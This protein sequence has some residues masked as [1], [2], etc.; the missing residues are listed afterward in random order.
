MS[1]ASR[2]AR[3]LDLE[4]TDPANVYGQGAFQRQV[5]S[6]G[7]LVWFVM[8][9]Q[10]LLISLLTPDI[11]Y[12]C[13]PPYGYGNLSAEEWQ[14]VSLP[15][16]D[17]GH[18]SRCS[19][20]DPPLTDPTESRTIV[21]C[22]DWS[23][24]T[25][26]TTL[27]TDKYLVC[28]RAWLVSLLTT[29]YMSGAVISVPF[30]GHFS[31]RIGRRP[32]ISAAVLVLILA[33]YAAYT[34]QTL[35]FFAIFRFFVAASVSVAH[36]TVLILIFEIQ[37]P[38]YRSYHCV[39]FQ[40]GLVASYAFVDGVG[41]FQLDYKTV[42][43]CSLVPTS[44]LICVFIMVDE[45]P[46]WLLATS[47]FQAAEQVVMRAIRLNGVDLRGAKVM[48]T[49]TVTE[50][51]KDD[52][53]S[54]VLM[55]DLSFLHL[56]FS[57]YLRKRSLILFWY[58]YTVA[59]SYY[60]VF[61]NV[62]VVHSDSWKFLDIG[63][64][65]PVYALFYYGMERYGRRYLQSA[66]T[67]TF[68][69]LCCA[70]GLVVNKGYTL[71]EDSLLT[72]MK[73]SLF[74][75][76][77]VLYVYN[78]ELYPTVMRSVGVTSGYFFGRLGS[79]CAALMKELVRTSGPILPLAILGGLSLSSGVLVLF[80]PETLQTRLPETLQ[81]LQPVLMQIPRLKKRRKHKSKKGKH[82]KSGEASAQ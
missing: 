71:L 7:Q 59:I 44:M 13:K 15:K 19:M 81:D 25:N 10:H 43:L 60:A 30:A 56:L 72:L 18:Y 11:D 82:K 46:R 32:V 76:L 3:E 26:Q 47:N 21:A 78:M 27:I 49:K 36:I 41:Y 23:F 69:V 58:W 4:N 31:D 80:L 16:D 63:L 9:V 24:E 20:Y 79:V 67:F 33:A 6:C 74:A 40:C 66:S 22:H 50:A 73:C 61:L 14:N 75:M 48:W 28:D 45:S 68:G 62:I 65:A 52:Q 37:T 2:G 1:S 17:D 53:G 51:S 70:L 54:R 57:P 5:L 38:P 64:Q 12:W 35:I 8:S 77:S 29:I 39:L 55:V 34:T 42:Q